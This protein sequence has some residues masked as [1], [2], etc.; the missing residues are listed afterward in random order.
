MHTH[1]YNT[2]MHQ[3][4]YYDKIIVDNCS[5]QYK[6]IKESSRERLNVSTKTLK[7]YLL[8]CHIPVGTTR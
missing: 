8:F 1:L 7:T 2:V 4:I 6:D 3:I 5:D